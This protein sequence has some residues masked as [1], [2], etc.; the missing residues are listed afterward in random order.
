M[1]AEPILFPEEIEAIRSGLLV[2]NSYATIARKLDRDRSTIVRHARRLG[3]RST[4]VRGRPISVG[5]PAVI[6]ARIT[7][8]ESI[9]RIASDLGCDSKTIWSIAM[10]LGVRSQHKRFGERA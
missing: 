7:A 3:L 10:R 8:G 4:D 9:R 5:D 1:P 2:G 6:C